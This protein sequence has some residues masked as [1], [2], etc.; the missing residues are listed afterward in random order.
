MGINTTFTIPASPDVELHRLFSNDTEALQ[1][2]LFFIYNILL[3]SAMVFGIVTVL[4]TLLLCACFCP[5]LWRPRKS[6]YTT[7][8]LSYIPGYGVLCMLRRKIIRSS[9]HQAITHGTKVLQKKMGNGLEKVTSILGSHKIFTG[10]LILLTFVGAF[11]LFKRRI[12]RLVCRVIQDEAIEE[13]R[14]QSVIVEKVFRMITASAV[15]AGFVGLFVDSIAFTKVLALLKDIALVKN[16]SIFCAGVCS[17]LSG[18]LSSFFSAI[19][20]FSVIPGLKKVF[21]GAK[22]IDRLVDPFDEEFS[23]LASDYVES[24]R[25]QDGS[26]KAMAKWRKHMEEE[27]KEV[28][29]KMGKVE[30]NT[31]KLFEK[32]KKDRKKN[33][34]SLIETPAMRM[35]DFFECMNSGLYPSEEETNSFSMEQLHYYNKHVL[36]KLRVTYSQETRKGKERSREEMLINDSDEGSTTE[37]LHMPFFGDI[38]DDGFPARAVLQGKH[39]KRI[40]YKSSSSDSDSDTEDDSH[41]Q[42]MYKLCAYIFVFVVLSLVGYQ[43]YC[44]LSPVDDEWEEGK[45]RKGKNKRGR[46]ALKRKARKAPRRLKPSEYAEYEKVRSIKYNKWL[47]ERD[48]YDKHKD[49]DL[50]EWGLE[51]EDPGDFDYSVHD[52]YW[53]FVSTKDEGTYEDMPVLVVSEGKTLPATFRRKLR[54]QTAPKQPRQRGLKVVTLKPKP[55]PVKQLPKKSE[56]IIM[57]ATEPFNPFEKFTPAVATVM[58]GDICS[59]DLPREKDDKGKRKRKKNHSLVPGSPVPPRNIDR[60]K[61]G[62]VRSYNESGALKLT[63]NAVLVAN[64]VLTALHV[65]NYAKT[66]LILG[67]R[68]FVIKFMQIP[69]HYF[70]QGIVSEKVDLMYAHRPTGLTNRPYK[71]GQ[72]QE[73][74]EVWVVGYEDNR[75]ELWQT[76]GHLTALKDPFLGTPMG[77]CHTCSSTEGL[78]GAPLLSASGTVVGVHIMGTESGVA[79][80]NCCILFDS[81]L[82]HFF[83]QPGSKITH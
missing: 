10:S 71:V 30:K 36:P 20:L 75:P 4:C 25:P 67:E 3:P 43:L 51:P 68:T 49:D 39:T 54:K 13:A 16:A 34:K 62:L 31:S 17:E 21:K 7:K 19:G 18:M 26:P 23:Q 77:M 70:P 82:L 38:K 64:V 11:V 57:T 81:G 5:S 24:T 69:S 32:Y 46:G 52:Y 63:G 56:A 12:K 48:Y 66:E 55:A 60:V 42:F 2:I 45:T 41:T 83:G 74:D 35:K 37:E 22:K 1:N 53:E 58:V 79:R 73:G 6:S 80:S 29:G 59:H 40:K 8:V 44:K 65:G 47:E 50:G 76:Y 33:K 15:T 61:H 78:S 27:F 14:K 28:M 9:V 72:A